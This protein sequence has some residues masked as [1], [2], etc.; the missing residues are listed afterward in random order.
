VADAAR[1]AE[2]PPNDDIANATTV[3]AGFSAVLDTTG[4]SWRPYIHVATA[5]DDLDD[6]QVCD[7]GGATLFETEPGTVYY[8]LLAEEDN[9]T[10][11]GGTLHISF[12]TPPPL[13]TTTVRLSHR[14]VVYRNGNARLHGTYTCVNGSGFFDTAVAL[15]Q[16]GNGVAY[17]S[18]DVPA[19]SEPIC[20][21]TRHRWSAP[22]DPYAE[23]APTLRP[24]PAFAQMSWT[25][26]GEWECIYGSTEKWV[27][28]K[29]WW[30]RRR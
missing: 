18:S 23:P 14:G 3:T 13:P 8:I 10:E 22:T 27:F 30:W 15:A 11:I 1:A 19:Y 9:Q 5:F 6:V 16:K 17:L 2:P 21:G 29:P 25:S 7:A 26:C 20:D 28:L 12:G 4:S 24:G